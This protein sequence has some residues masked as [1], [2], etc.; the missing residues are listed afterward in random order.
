MYC[1]VTTTLFSRAENIFKCC[2]HIWRWRW[3]A[4]SFVSSWDRNKLLC[5]EQKKGRNHRKCPPS[6]N[7]SQAGNHSILKCSTLFSNAGEPLY[8]QVLLYRVLRQSPFA[9]TT[10][11]QP[12]YSQVLEPRHDDQSEGVHVI[13]EEEHHDDHCSESEL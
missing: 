7:Q 11:W 4:D 1:P 6:Y 13:M 3:G 9:S 8:S 2:S 12:H 10:L 5:E